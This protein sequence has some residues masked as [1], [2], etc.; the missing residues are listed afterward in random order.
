MEW[1]QPVVHT[2]DIKQTVAISASEIADCDGLKNDTF[3]IICPNCRNV[4][5]LHQ[6][7]QMEILETLFTLPTGMVLVPLELLVDVVLA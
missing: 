3:N 7:M 2:A 1:L 5:N 4:F 6:N